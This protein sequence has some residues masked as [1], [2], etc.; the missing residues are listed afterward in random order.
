MKLLDGREL[1][2]YITERQARQVRALRQASSVFPKLA[3]VLTVDDP[4]IN[5]YIR[6]KQAYGEDILIDTEVHKVTDGQIVELIKTLNAD[7]T[8]HGIIVQ[9]PLAKGLDTD[10]ILNTIAPEKDVDGLRSDATWTPATAMA[11][12]WLL[13]GYNI[14][15]KNKKIAIVGNGRLV[16]KPLAALWASMGLPFDIY[17]DQTVDLPSEVRKAQ[18]IVTATG[19][20]GLIT[21]TMV[22]PGA[23]VV[24]AGTA[25]ENGTIV[26]DVARDV[27]E[28]DDL[29]ITPERGGVGPLT[30]VALFDNVIR[31]AQATIS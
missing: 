12:D 19:V 26:G 14:E 22:Q 7:A 10:T 8:I 16:G 30:V 11:I 9:L 29:T 13:A 15:L 4:V 5:T 27:R 25:S 3:I 23:V 6:M 21:S 17:D 1:A 18:V 31:A 2:G 24:D 28:R 20:P